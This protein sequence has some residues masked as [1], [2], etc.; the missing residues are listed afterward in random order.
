MFSNLM[1]SMHLSSIVFA[2]NIAGNFRRENTIISLYESFSCI[3]V[4]SRLRWLFYLIL[5]T[6][7]ISPSVVSDWRKDIISQ[8]KILCLMVTRVHVFSSAQWQSRIQIFLL[9]WF[10]HFYSMCINASCVWYMQCSWRSEEGVSSPELELQM[11]MNHH[12]DAGDRP[13]FSSYPDK[14]L[15]AVFHNKII[16]TCF[17]YSMLRD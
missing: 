2:K 17:I 15:K 11:A 13:Q 6:P 16:L 8:D 10:S 14:F 9:K 4:K 7:D 5:I 3:I 1:G 12:M